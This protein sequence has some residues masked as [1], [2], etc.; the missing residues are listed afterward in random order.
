[1]RQ[2]LHCEAEL[3]ARSSAEAGSCILP[4]LESDSA[5]AFPARSK[6]DS[7]LVEWNL[8]SGECDS[9]WQRRCEGCLPATSI[10]WPGRAGSTVCWGWGSFSG[11][12]STP[13]PCRLHTEMRKAA[14]EESWGALGSCL[15]RLTLKDWSC[16]CMSWPLQGLLWRPQVSMWEVGGLH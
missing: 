3:L 12:L 4:V 8:S 2:F 6:P 16:C 9:W 5:W 1:M 7:S 15:P 13:R 11:L 10:S 14:L